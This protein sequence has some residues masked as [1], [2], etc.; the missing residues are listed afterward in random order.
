M[1]I[2]LWF[3]YLTVLGI[4]TYINMAKKAYLENLSHIQ[5]LNIFSKHNFWLKKTCAGRFEAVTSHLAPKVTVW[6]VISDHM[7]SYFAHR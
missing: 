7:S 2:F 3:K 1:D 5:N 6:A 4:F